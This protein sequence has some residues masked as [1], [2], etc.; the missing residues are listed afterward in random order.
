MRLGSDIYMHLLYLK[1]T[2][3]IIITK[4][5]LSMIKYSKPLLSHFPV[6]LFNEKPTQHSSFPSILKQYNISGDIF[7]Y[8]QNILQESV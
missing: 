7:I 3:I 5:K 8:I 4:Y 6:V 2:S 1:A